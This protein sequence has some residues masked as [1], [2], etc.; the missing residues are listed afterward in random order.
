[1]LKRTFKFVDYEGNDR[2]EEHYFYLN[3]SEIIKWITTTGDYSLDRLLERLTKERNGKEIIRI[4][5]DLI[6]QSYGVKSLDGR[7]FVKNQQVWEDFYQTE[8]Y[9]ELFME[10]VTD[11]KKA[12]EFVNAI[13]PK[14]IASEVEKEMSKNKLVDYSTVG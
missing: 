14:D 7:K 4:F 5:E 1:M 6:R 2:E 12:A 11:A 13:I 9:S 10:L 8:A 3:K